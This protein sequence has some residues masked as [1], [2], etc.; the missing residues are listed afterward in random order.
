MDGVW[1]LDSIIAGHLSEAH[2]DAVHS[3][4]AALQQA[5]R[6]AAGRQTAVERYDAAHVDG[7]RVQ[8][9]LQLQT[10]PA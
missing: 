7:E 9:C 6:E 10:R 3:R 4:R 1:L 5:V 8:R 2:V